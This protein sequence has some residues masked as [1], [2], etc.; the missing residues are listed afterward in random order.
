MLGSILI[1]MLGG[2]MFRNVKVTWVVGIAL[3]AVSWGMLGVSDERTTG[4]IRFS[5]I[6]HIIFSNFG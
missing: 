6:I 5:N 2:R 1:S 4:I 3:S